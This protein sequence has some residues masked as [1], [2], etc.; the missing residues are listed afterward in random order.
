MTSGQ[1]YDLHFRGYAPEAG[2]TELRGIY[3]VGY[4]LASGAGGL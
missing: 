3:T 2:I 1:G 4:E